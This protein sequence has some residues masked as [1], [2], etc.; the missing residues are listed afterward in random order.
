MTTDVLAVETRT[1][2]D[3]LL[4][5]ADT[6]LVLGNWFAECVTNGKSLPDFAAM[7]GMCTASYGQTRAIY[8]YLDTQGQS[9]R[10]LETG[11]TAEGIRSMDTL[12][13]APVNW[14][15]FVVS[16]WL[17]EQAVW[18]LASGYLDHPDRT[19]AGICRKIGEEAYFHLQYAHGWLK[20]FLASD[21]EAHTVRDSAARRVPRTLRWLTVDGAPELPDSLRETYRRTRYHFMYEAN[22]RLAPF[23]TEASQLP[24]LTH[25]GEW[26]AE[27]R[28][29]GELPAALFEVIRFKD[30]DLAR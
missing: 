2:L 11:R 7:L 28:R 15:D 29:C 14:P 27:A 19:V 9:Y 22:L 3:D 17:C 1:L 20:I 5:I 26:R 16:A 23:G 6:K 21:D 8:H 4:C 10:N 18:S 25:G 24:E 30:P 13:E 12:D